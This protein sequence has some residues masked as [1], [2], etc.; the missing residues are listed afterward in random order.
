MKAAVLMV[1]L[2]TPQAPDVAAVRRFTGTFLSDPRVVEV[3]RLI[4]WLI[5][6]GAILPFRPR[7][8]AR[9]YAE[10]W[11]EYGDSPLRHYSRA[12]CAALA[13][14]FADR[15]GE[16]VIVA[17]AVTY[18]SP[19]IA[20]CLDEF[21]R[22]GVEQLIVLPLY[23]QYSATTSGAVFDQVA[24]KLMATRDI[25]ALN[26]IRSY[27][28]H[29]LYIDALA[30]SVEAHWRD[31]GRGERLL[32]SFHGIPQ[33][34]VDLGDPYLTQA[35]QTCQLLSARL[36]L[37]PDQWAISFQSRLGRAQWLQPYTSGLLKEWGELGVA[38]VD[39]ICPA[40]AADC[41]ETIEEIAIENRDVFFAAGGKTFHYIPCLNDQPA[42]IDLFQALCE[43][44][45]DWRIDAASPV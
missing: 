32:M 12:Q 2:G 9:A 7:R 6:H 29:P 33:R 4:W 26:L 28:D 3:P 34:N 40:F 30:A 25:P 13:K 27:H 17:N 36:N 38:S 1:W 16:Q 10:I 42:H 5:L 43:Q 41:L 8:T 39:V 21:S 37:R 44:Q 11:H 22:Q 15:Y 14:R 35:R 20:E 19:S 24:R 18:G 45:L 23:P 31:H